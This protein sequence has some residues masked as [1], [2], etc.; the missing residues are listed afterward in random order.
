MKPA[1]SVQLNLV[2]RTRR[3][4]LKYSRIRYELD[5]DFQTIAAC[6]NA[7]RA[8]L[9]S[10]NKLLSIY[11]L[12]LQIRRNTHSPT[13]N[14]ICPVSAPVQA[15]LGAHSLWSAPHIAWTPNW[16]GKHA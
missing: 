11:K 15:V 1:L 6:I 16:Y 5:P 8:A 10:I 2:V 7:L 3:A 9:I 4:N 12:R 13:L 14:P